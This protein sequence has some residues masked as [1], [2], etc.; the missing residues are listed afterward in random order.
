M[1][2]VS[3]VATRLVCHGSK[4]SHGLPSVL[5]AKSNLIRDGSA[6]S[7]LPDRHKDL[8]VVS[9]MFFPVEV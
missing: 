8:Q 6:D 5:C 3:V 7:Q 1:A 4:W 9:A 2:T